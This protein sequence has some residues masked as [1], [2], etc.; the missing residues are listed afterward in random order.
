MR[1]K[2][3]ESELR[4]LEGEQ[5]KMHDQVRAWMRRAVAA[6]RRAGGASTD[7]TETL[8]AAVAGRLDGGIGTRRRLNW[9]ERIE[10]RRAAA[11]ATSTAAPGTTNGGGV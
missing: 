11:R 7:G 2:R 3:L 8:P 1:V 5:L 6:E 4:I 9:R 10:A